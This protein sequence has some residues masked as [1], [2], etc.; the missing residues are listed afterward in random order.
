[1]LRLLL[2]VAEGDDA[3]RRAAVLPVAPPW[4][5]GPAPW[6]ARAAAFPVRV[7]PRAKGPFAPRERE[8]FCKSLQMFDNFLGCIE[9]DVC[10]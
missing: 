5:G 9:A 1:M 2:A 7:A 3:F 10:E 4:A 8:S 6:A